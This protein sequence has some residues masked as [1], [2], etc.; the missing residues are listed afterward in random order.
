MSQLLDDLR[1]N[2]QKMAEFRRQHFTHPTL[3]W[4]CFEE[5]VLKLGTPYTWAPRPKNFQAGLPK[6]CF[7]NS[8]LLALRRKNLVYVEGFALLGNIGLPIHHAWVIEQDSDVVI[9]VTSDN[10]RAYIGI[11]FRTDYLRQRRKATDSASLLDDSKGKFPLMRMDEAEILP[12]MA[13]NNKICAVNPKS[14]V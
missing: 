12:L 10:F 7:N 6:A 13:Q 3:K 4:C 1:L 11:P 14:L 2:L 9:D 8:G 5:L